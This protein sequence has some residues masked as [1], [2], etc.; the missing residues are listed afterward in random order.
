MLPTCSNDH[1]G[2]MQQYAGDVYSMYVGARALLGGRVLQDLKLSSHG[3]HVFRCVS[4]QVY[5][6]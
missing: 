3:L 6:Q 2:V 5:A 4:V 1:I